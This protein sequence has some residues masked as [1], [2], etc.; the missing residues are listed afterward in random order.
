MRPTAGLADKT[1]LFQRVRAD[2]EDQVQ[3]R[4]AAAYSTR[5]KA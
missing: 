2:D 4:Q 1:C 3:L 5:K